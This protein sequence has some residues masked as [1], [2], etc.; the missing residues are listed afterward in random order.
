MLEKDFLDW[1][2]FQ[3]IIENMEVSE[4]ESADDGAAQ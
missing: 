2:G 4:N 3:K 1:K